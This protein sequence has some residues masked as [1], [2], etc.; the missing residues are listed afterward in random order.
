M[1]ITSLVENTTE[2]DWE[3]EHGLSLYIEACGLKILFDCGQT[4]LFAKNALKAGVDLSEVDAFVLSHGHYDH[5]GGLRVFARI[6]AKAP[7]YASRHAFEDHWHGDERYT[8]L[9][10]R[11]LD[12]P[13]FAARIVFT[14]GAAQLAPGV[15]LLGSEGRETFVDMGAAGL[16]VRTAAGFVPDDFRHE[17]YLLLEENGRRVL[18]SGCS[19]KGVVNIAKWFEPDVLVGGFHFMREPCDARLE[20]LAETLE[21]MPVEFHTCHCTGAEQYAFI[22]RFMTRLH[23]LSEGQ[24]LEI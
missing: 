19:H 23:Y 24:V 9:D 1:K 3:V 4:D 16:T 8:G 6:N 15:S 20:R 7:I 18:M 13:A 14:G 21:A 2:L 10:A 17:Q 11:L 5:G 22:S 12:D